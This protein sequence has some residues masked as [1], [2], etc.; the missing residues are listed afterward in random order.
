MTLRELLSTSYTWLDEN[1]LWVL[2]AGVAI[3][4]V[5]TVAAWIGKG[6]RTDRDGRWIASTLVGFGLLALM[7]EVIALLVARLA[8][9]Q[10]IADANAYLLLAPVVCLVGC[11]LGIRSVFP[12][13]ELAS[14]KTFTDIMFF[15]LA[16]AAVLW[17]FSAFRGWGI[18]FL[19]GI[20]Q[21]VIICALAFFVLRRLY[22]RVTG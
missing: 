4:V 2:A 5:G 3:P 15:V 11:L 19:G 21:L 16:C 22:R 7:G 13:T 12:L 10:P 6:G 9:E 8:F 20:G 1:A 17:F 18:V 14:F